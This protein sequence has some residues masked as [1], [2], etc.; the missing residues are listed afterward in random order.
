MHDAAAFLWVRCTLHMDV[1][2]AYYPVLCGF[3]WLWQQANAVEHVAPRLAES[4]PIFSPNW[5]LSTVKIWV[6]L[7]FDDV[8]L[9]I[10]RGGAGLE[11]WV[12]LGWETVPRRA[13]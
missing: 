6:W 8:H 11:R 13:A 2:P 3:A 12:W 1:W 10:S 7:F 5:D 9:M 4:V